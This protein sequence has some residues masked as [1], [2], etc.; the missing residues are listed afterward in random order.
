MSEKS[1]IAK[2]EEVILR[3]TKPKFMD[4]KEEVNKF[5]DE[6]SKISD[7]PVKSI[8]KSINYNGMQIFTFG[9]EKSKNTILY[10]A[11]LLSMR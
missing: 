4:S 1:F 6:R 11:E 3:F 9:D 10:M 7:K 2:I 5:L 8:F